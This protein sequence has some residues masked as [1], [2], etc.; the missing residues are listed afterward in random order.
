MAASTLSRTP[1][2]TAA[3]THVMAVPE[4]RRPWTTVADVAR[5]LEPGLVLADSLSGAEVVEAFR[6]TPASE[7][8]VV[9]RDGGTVGVLAAADVARILQGHSSPVGAA[10]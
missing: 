4:A 2:N 7:Y 5:P 1:A 6:R 3:L 8:L 10:A 9:G